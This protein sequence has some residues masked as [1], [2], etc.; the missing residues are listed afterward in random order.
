MYGVNAVNGACVYNSYIYGS[1]TN[2]L[3]P[4]DTWT[5][6]YKIIIIWNFKS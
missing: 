5:G 2:P 4:I 6:K 3:D 1:I